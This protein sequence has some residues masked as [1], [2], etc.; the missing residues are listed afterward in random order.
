MLTAGA[1]EGVRIDRTDV[2]GAASLAG[3][4][5]G[6]IVVASS[7]QTY[8]TEATINNEGKII[9]SL[10]FKKGEKVAVVVTPFK[11]AQE[12]LDE[13]AWIRLGLENFFK[14]DAEGDAAYDLL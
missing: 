4:S 11:D 14:D 8:S 3:H 1:G 13:E 9:L 2:Y 6:R 7:M 5:E 12:A 10:P